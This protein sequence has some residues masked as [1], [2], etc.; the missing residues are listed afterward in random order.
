MKTQ[1]SI[2]SAAMLAALAVAACRKEEPTNPS[3]FAGPTAT[4]TDTTA[5][6]PVTTTTAPPPPPPA[7]S[8]APATAAPPTCD[9][10]AATMLSALLT[11]LQQQFAPGT[12]AVGSVCGIGQPGAVIEVPFQIQPGKCY[13]AIGGGLPPLTQ[14]D[15]QLVTKGPA[16]TPPVVLATSTGNGVQP[17]IGGK[18]NCIKNPLPIGGPGALVLKFTAGQGAAIATVYEK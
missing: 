6:P 1:I 12:K 13:A 7:S 9:P 16:G 14:I 3:A 5:T 18:P 8:T 10:A 17:V 2:V 4:A 15:L 11:P